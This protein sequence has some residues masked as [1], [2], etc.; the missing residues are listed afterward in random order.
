M[1]IGFY[2]FP[3]LNCLT[4]MLSSAI[5]WQAWL[6]LCSLSPGVTEEECTAAYEFYL[7]QAFEVYD[8]CLKALMG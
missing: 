5:E 2:W 7:A 3:G 6:V 4:S 1:G 8:A